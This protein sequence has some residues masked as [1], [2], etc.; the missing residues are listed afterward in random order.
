MIINSYFTNGYFEWGK[1][2]VESF[3]YHN[4]TDFQMILNTKDLNK[5]QINELKSLYPNLEVINEKLD[6]NMLAKKSGTSVKQLKDYKS[7]TEKQKVNVNN[8]VWKL[9]IAGD[10]RIKTVNKLLNTLPEGEYLA[11]FDIDTYV[12][13]NLSELFDFVK[14]NDF[15]TKYRIK[16]QINRRG[17]VFKENGATLIYFMGFTVNDMSKEFMTRWIKHI[18]KVPPIKRQKGYG[19]ITCYYAYLEMIKNPNF[20]T[21]DINPYKKWAFA[22]KGSKTKLYEKFRNSFEKLKNKTNK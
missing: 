3:A 20:R 7:V 17:N 16:K 5:K 11:H 22:N 6:W 2:F 9:M 1:L 15:C 18:N 19:Q 12:T 10:D 13:G 8:K 14:V 21:G 4:G